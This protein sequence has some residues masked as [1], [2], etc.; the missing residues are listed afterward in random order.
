MHPWEFNKDLDT[1]KSFQAFTCYRDLGP[2]R[3]LEDAYQV[4][5]ERQGSI[6][7]VSGRFSDWSSKGQWVK[8]AL[9]F[10][11]ENDRIWLEGKR[12]HDREDHDRRI[13]EIRALTEGLSIARLASSLRAAVLVRDTIA[14]LQ[15]RCTRDGKAILSREDA[16]FLLT[17]VSIQS[18][19]AS[20]IETSL[21]LADE[22]LAISALIEQLAE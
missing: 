3:S 11:L 5:S 18:K 8:R 20:T 17:L 4:Y 19:D 10:D 6:K 1:A 13:E 12:I 16:D 9:A 21:K 7:R 22:S 2:M 15:E 14:T